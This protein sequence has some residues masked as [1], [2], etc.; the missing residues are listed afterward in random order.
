MNVSGLGEASV[1]LLARQISG[2]S[3][4]GRG[5]TGGSDGV[6]GMLRS[7][8][9]IQPNQRQPGSCNNFTF[10]CTLYLKPV[11]AIIRYIMTQRKR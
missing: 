8:A 10:M 4:R 5:G 9:S 1:P 11:I 7:V 6:L 2:G 3:E